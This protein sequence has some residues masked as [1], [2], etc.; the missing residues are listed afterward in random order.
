MHNQ[1]TKVDSYARRMMRIPM[2]TM[3]CV[4]LAFVHAVKIRN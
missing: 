3:N 2:W 1:A 4:E